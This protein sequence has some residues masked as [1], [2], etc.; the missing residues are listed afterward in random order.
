MRVASVGARRRLCVRVCACMCLAVTLPLRLLTAL[1][2]ISAICCKALL[3]GIWWDLA[4]SALF[5]LLNYWMQQVL[6]CSMPN[7]YFSKTMAVKSYFPHLSYFNNWWVSFTYVFVGFVLFFFL[8]LFFRLCSD[9]ICTRL[10][11]DAA[12]NTL[13]DCIND[14]LQAQ[15]RWSLP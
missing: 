11:G 2:T 7:V 3:F 15:I 6:R 9:Y 13:Y 5:T 1:F 10:S 14:G 4:G 12:W 8:S